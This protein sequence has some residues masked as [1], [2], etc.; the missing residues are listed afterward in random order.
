M[1]FSHGCYFGYGQHVPGS[2]FREGHVWAEAERLDSVIR[3]IRDVAPRVGQLTSGPYDQ[4]M[5]FLVVETKPDWDY[6]V[7]LGTFRRIDPVTDVQHYADWNAE[8]ARA[9][10]A[11]GYDPAAFDLPGWLVVPD[12][13]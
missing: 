12:M 6:E 3:G 1:G 13:S 9:V 11:A 7:E 4:D 2:Q 5:L 10:K 8:L